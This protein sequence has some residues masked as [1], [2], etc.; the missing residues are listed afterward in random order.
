MKHVQYRFVSRSE[1]D[2]FEVRNQELHST[3]RTGALDT[4]L[5]LLAAGADPNY[6]HPVNSCIV[7]F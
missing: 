1:S 3:V 5:R 6:F 2:S 4:T 7:I